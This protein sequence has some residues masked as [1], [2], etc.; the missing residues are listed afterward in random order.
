MET[1]A[2]PIPPMAAPKQA[3]IRK[4]PPTQGPVEGP[5]HSAS[6]HAAAG[7][8]RHTMNAIRLR[9]VGKE[10]SGM[11]RLLFCAKSKRTED[12]VAI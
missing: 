8:S 11:N 5:S 7:E 12:E 10:N 3:A 2:G 1:R 4:I 6:D 9:R